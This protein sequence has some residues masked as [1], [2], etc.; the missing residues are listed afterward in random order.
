MKG[1]EKLRAVNI[2]KALQAVLWISCNLISNKLNFK[3]DIIEFL[4]TLNLVG[5]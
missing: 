1:I 2:L 5:G 3:K 4:A